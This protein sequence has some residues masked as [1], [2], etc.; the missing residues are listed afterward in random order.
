MKGELNMV[1]KE[2]VDGLPMVFYG[3]STD[4]K[5]TEET[6]NGAVFY[7]MDTK[8]MYMFDGDTSTWLEQ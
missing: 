3:K 4:R 1:T 2:Y 5:P 7:E 8:K 6:K